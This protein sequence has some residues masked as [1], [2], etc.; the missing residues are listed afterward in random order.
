MS[1]VIVIG[2]GPAGMMAAI[3]AA[4]NGA[5]VH[6][7]EKKDRVGKKM[8]I[9]GKGRCNITNAADMQEILK[10]IPGNGSF[11]HSAFKAFDNQN[12]IQFFEDAGVP[13]KVERGGRVFPVSDR[14]D[15]C[16]NAML[17]ALHEANVEIMSD[18]EVK[19][20]LI[21]DKKI[22]GVQLAGGTVLNADAVILAAGGASYPR[23]GS[24][25]AGAKLAQETG[26]TIKTLL[27][28]LVP[29][30]T[31]DEWVYELQGLSLKNVRVA[32]IANG[33]KNKDAFGEMMFTHFGVTGPI[34]LTLSRDAAFALASRK[35]VELELNLKPAL[36]Q[37]QIQ[38]RVE[39][40]FETYQK[41]SIKNAM[42][43]LLP[44]RMIPII[45]DLAYI[46]AE[47]Q[48]NQITRPERLRLAELLQHISISVS[49]TRPLAEAIV[50][51]G[52]VSVKEVNPKTMESKL[53]NGLY[54]AGEII[55]V[56]C[57]TG[58]YNLQVAWS[59]G[60]TAGIS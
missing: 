49:K 59:T 38:K 48:V 9:T 18:T 14:A 46:D 26:H 25:G 11:L 2:A 19:H 42:H 56:D 43:N 35:E 32:L 39:R 15:D 37:E 10:N 4:R 16:V 52:G 21:H 7:L 31:E 28:A 50:T 12:V 6:L 60:Y 58:G 22:A 17:H 5:E 53:I 29:L 8:R 45:L 36:T 47:K 57:L 40:D 41:K 33:E 30:E 1:K 55:D 44:A 23:T 13:T 3:M 27:P 54:F 34:I 20:I 24:D 51:C